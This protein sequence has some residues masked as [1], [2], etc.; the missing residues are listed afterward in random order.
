MPTDDRYEELERSLTRLVR[1]AFL[2]TTGEATRR[3]AGVHLERATYSALVRTA[4]LDGGR[5]SDIA[6]LLGV[7]ISTASRH[8]KRLVDAGYVAVAPDP[9]DA[10][11][12]RYTPTEQGRDALER[13]RRARRETLGR[14]LDDWSAGD[15]ETLARG[16]DRLLDALEAA[17]AARA[18]DLAGSGARGTP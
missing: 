3:A 10:R 2:P 1:R 15:V 16:L 4:E 9:D 13:V 7:E 8:L 12:R 18:T 17:E 14:I 11:A 5:L 6:A